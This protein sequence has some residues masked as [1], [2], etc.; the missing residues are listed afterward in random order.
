MPRLPQ[1]VRAVGDGGAAEVEVEAVGG[2]GCV[3]KGKYDVQRD[4]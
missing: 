4:E 1:N 3:G 2:H